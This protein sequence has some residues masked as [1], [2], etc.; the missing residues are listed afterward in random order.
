MS[1]AYK[2][3][4][5]DDKIFMIDSIKNGVTI[6]ELSKELDRSDAS[7]I[8][9][10][11]KLLEINTE[12]KQSY[13]NFVIDNIKSNYDNIFTHLKNLDTKSTKDNIKSIDLENELYDKQLEAFEY[14]KK[15]HNLF[16]TGEGGVG[17][18]KIT[19]TIINYFKDKNVQI[20]VTGSTGV[21]ATLING[22]TIHSFMGIGLAKKSADELYSSMSNANII[23]LQKLQVLIIDEIS[24]INNIL[25]SKIS[26]ILSLIK[27]IKKQFG[28]IQVI[29]VGDF[30]QL[31]PVTHKY[32]F[33]SKAWDKLNLKNIVLDKQM[34]QNEDIEFQ[35]ILSYLRFNPLNNEIY[36]ILK[37]YINNNIDSK[38]KP[39]ILYSKNVNV[40][41][42]NEEHYNNTLK[43][44][45]YK[46]H[47]FPIKYDE[48]KKTI[49]NL[50]I[51]TFNNTH[52]KLCKGLQVM[53]TH[54]L[55][56]ENK[57]VNGTRAIIED[58]TD[59]IITIIT[60]D[61]KVHFISYIDHMDENNKKKV[62]YKY[63]PLKLA[64]SIT[65]HKI[66]GMTLDCVKMDLGTDIF[67]YGQA[68][69]ALSRAKSLKY[70]NLI[71]LDM[72]SFK[73]NPEVKNFYKKIN[74]E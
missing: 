2:R 19:K 47:I 52:I 23:K 26:K 60:C 24:M 71:N 14:A 66:Q 72:D 68:Y 7:V 58:I 74:Y 15:G 63:I 13:Y 9:Q 40:D 16:I 38:V 25:F 42:M 46:E 73:C 45:N 1:N 37:H 10:L 29:L 65:V 12:Y 22:T 56:I 54:N 30:T 31:P 6:S 53:V 44:N 39:T 62:L 34:R 8:I 55:N 5:K 51:K 57:L 69:T 43:E 17:K 32:C 61:N 59:D 18:S 67:T 21:S 41:I 64:H 70:I 4:T 35:K 28:G 33:E 20:G 11:N 36:N 49:K 50:I 3:W 48:S 27:G